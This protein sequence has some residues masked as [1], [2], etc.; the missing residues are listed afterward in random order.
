MEEQPAEEW[1]VLV[2]PNSEHVLLAQPLHPGSV[3]VYGHWRRDIV[4]HG[5]IDTKICSVQK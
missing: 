2:C 5:K 1:A 3:A 4:G